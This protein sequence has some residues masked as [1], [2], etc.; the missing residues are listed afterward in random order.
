MLLKKHFEK[1]S[2]SRHYLPRC[3]TTPEYESGDRFPP[4]T[5][6]CP[7][8]EDLGDNNGNLDVN[9]KKMEFTQYQVVD[10]LERTNH[11]ISRDDILDGDIPQMDNTTVLA[12]YSQRTNIVNVT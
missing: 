9:G 5:T 7:T 6:P 3:R 8:A 11:V 4:Q 12:D 2:L 1:N 10:T